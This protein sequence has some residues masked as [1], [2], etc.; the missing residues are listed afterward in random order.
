M[1]FWFLCPLQWTTSRTCKYRDS[2]REECIQRVYDILVRW[3]INLIK[4][5]D[6]KHVIFEP[7]KNIYFS[8]YLPTLIHLFHPFTS[9]SKP[10]SIEVFDCCLSHFCTSVSTFSS[11]AKRFPPSCELLYA[12]NTSHHKQKISIW[13]YFA[14][15]LFAHKKRTTEH[16]SSVIHS[17]S[18]VAILTT[19][20]SLWTCASAT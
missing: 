1:N 3:T 11:S 17:S 20:N 8:T 6:I 15:S 14:L 9:A 19:E 13:M 10:C 7:G 18:A 12:T 5:M 16:C 4:Q 2:E